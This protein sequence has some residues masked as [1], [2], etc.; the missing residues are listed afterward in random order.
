MRLR[1]CGVSGSWGIPT[2][3]SRLY[4]GVS[5]RNLRQEQGAPHDRTGVRP[6]GFRD[7]RNR[8]FRAFPFAIGFTVRVA[9]LAPGDTVAGY[10]VLSRLGEG[11][12]GIVYLAEHIG[13][14]RKV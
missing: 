1:G 2:W 13:L 9:E 3:Q 12:M 11:G 10:H 5:A 14:G 7:F 4:G 6:R 8:P